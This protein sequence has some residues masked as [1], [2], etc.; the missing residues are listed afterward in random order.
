MDDTVTLKFDGISDAATYYV[1]SEE[2]YIPF[3]TYTGAQ[4]KKGIDLTIEESYGAEIVY[5]MDTTGRGR[6]RNG[7]PSEGFFRGNAC[8]ESADWN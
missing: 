1:W 3:A 7:R 2:G 5:F 4:L 6:G 8:R